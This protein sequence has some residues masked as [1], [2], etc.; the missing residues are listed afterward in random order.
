[1]LGHAREVVGDD[2]TSLLSCLSQDYVV[3]Q[4][5]ELSKLGGLKIDPGLSAQ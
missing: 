3:L 1:M 2:N 4:S 5:F